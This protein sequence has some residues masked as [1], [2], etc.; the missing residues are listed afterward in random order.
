MSLKLLV[1]RLSDSPDRYNAQSG[2]SL[3][4]R[5]VRA[6]SAYPSISDMIS[7]S[8]ARRDGPLPEVASSMFTTWQAPGRD[9]LL[10]EIS[11]MR[12]WPAEATHPELLENEQYFERRAQVPTASRGVGRRKDR[13]IVSFVTGV[14]HLSKSP[15]SPA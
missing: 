5:D 12:D 15:A 8:R 6:S 1:P 3:P 11:D 13:Y 7:R 14:V 4:K 9:E 10:T 2:Q